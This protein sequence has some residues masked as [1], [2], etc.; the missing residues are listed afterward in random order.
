M[1]RKELIDKIINYMVDN[2]YT[3]SNILKQQYDNSKYE[4]D[5]DKVGFNLF[6]TEY[7]G[8]LKTPKEDYEINTIGGRYNDLEV[9]FTVFIRGGILDEIEGYTYGNVEFP[10]NDDIELFELKF[11]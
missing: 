4:L 11:Q 5:E 10:N 9:G 8:D 2:N 1:N 7:K 3:H 6:L